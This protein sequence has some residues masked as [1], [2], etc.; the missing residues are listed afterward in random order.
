MR[1]LI[2][3][4]FNTVGTNA[5]LTPNFLNSTVGVTPAPVVVETAIGTGN[6]PPAKKLAVSPESATRLGSAR[7]RTSPFV[8]SALT[9]TSIFVPS[10]IRLANT[11]PNGSPVLVLRMAPA[12]F[13]TDIP[14]VLGLVV[15]VVAVVPP[16]ALVMVL[17]EG[18]MLGVPSPVLKPR[19][20]LA[21]VP[22]QLTP[23]SRSA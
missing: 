14:P 4:W 11:T 22:N 3:P 17:V 9:I 8:S 20:P 18:K 12:D 2:K 13:M 21:L 6:S 15:V 10:W 23:R 16:E 5:R 7:R 19:V 1:R